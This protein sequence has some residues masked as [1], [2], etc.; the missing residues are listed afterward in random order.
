MIK[1]PAH[2]KRSGATRSTVKPGQCPRAPPRLAVRRQ[3]SLTSPPHRPP[4]VRRLPR[5]LPPPIPVAARLRKIVL[6]APLPCRRLRRS[7]RPRR[8]QMH[9]A[10]RPP[11]VPAPSRRNSAWCPVGAAALCL[12]APHRAVCECMR[13]PLCAGQH[14]RPFQKAK[15]LKQERAE[16]AH[17]APSAG[18]LPA[19]GAAHQP[20]ITFK[21]AVAPLVR[22]PNRSFKC[23]YQRPGPG[24]AVLGQLQGL[25]G[26]DP[27]L[28]AGQPSGGLWALKAPCA[29]VP[30][31]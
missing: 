20:A 30:T 17:A 26:P 25:T 23:L 4:A 28:R 12:A 9:L 6:P 16:Q 13:C 15:P 14:Q 3:S 11:P 22:A 24:E 8:R 10:G 19:D 29:P 31:N 27:L 1:L 18:C 7:L 21:R 2:I 5:M